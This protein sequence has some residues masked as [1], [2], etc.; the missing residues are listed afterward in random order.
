MM[1]FTLEDYEKIAGITKKFAGLQINW[2]DYE[3]IWSCFV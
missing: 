1:V 2:Q 3:K